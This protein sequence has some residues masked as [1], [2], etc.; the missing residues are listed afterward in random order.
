MR[1]QA[2]GTQVWT[3]SEGNIETC[4]I[5]MK[6]GVPFKKLWNPY[7]ISIQGM[8]SPLLTC[9]LLVQVGILWYHT[10]TQLRMYT[11]TQLHTYVYIHV[12]KVVCE[13][14]WTYEH[15]HRSMGAEHPLVV[16]DVILGHVGGLASVSSAYTLYG[17]PHS[18]TA[19]QISVWLGI[20]SF[21]VI[22][23]YTRGLNQW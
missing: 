19:L 15:A 2:S 17:I 7:T 9:A 18:S 8:V 3:E 10:P 23:N 11:L 12:L 14:I 6:T 13:G 22:W 1:Q 21:F 20:Y 5:T 4:Q 16:W